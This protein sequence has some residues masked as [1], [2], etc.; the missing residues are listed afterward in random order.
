MENTLDDIDAEYDTKLATAM[1][2]IG[3]RWI[4]TNARFHGA[5]DLMMVRA[6]IYPGREILSL[7]DIT[8]PWTPET[9]R[10]VDN[11]SMWVLD[12][13]VLVCRGCGI[14]GT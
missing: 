12:D 13:L 1:D 2:A 6:G 3:A 8:Y 14:N 4:P 7:P 10:D 11:P 9:C 5:L